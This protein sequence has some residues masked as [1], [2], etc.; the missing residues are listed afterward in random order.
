MIVNTLKAVIETGRPRIGTR[1]LFVVFRLMQPFT[2]A[3]CRSE[4]WPIDEPST[5]GGAS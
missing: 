5:S 1:M 3:K 2:P 4:H